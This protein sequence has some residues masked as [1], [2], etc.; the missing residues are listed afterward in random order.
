[1]RILFDL[2]HPAH[3]HFFR[4][5][6]ARL[7]GEGHEVRFTGRDKDILVELARAYGIPLEVFGVAPKAHAATGVRATTG[8]HAVENALHL[9][10]ELLQRQWHLQR[11]IRQWRPDAMMAIAG[12]YVSSLGYLLRV[13][14]YVFYDTEHAT[15]S[16]LLAYPF[17]TCIYV[18]RCYRKAIRWRHERYNGY[19]ELAYLHPRYF[20]PD[21]AVMGE[22]GLAPGERFAIVRLV[23]WG[24]AH[25]IGRAGFT[26]EN[27]LRLV[28]ELGR[29]ARV[30]VSCEGELPR[31]L[32]PQRLRLPVARI[33]HLMAH[34]ALVFGESATM[35]SE[36]AVLG[37]P[38]VYVDPVG[39]GYTDEEE[40][41]YG[42]VFNFT[43]ERQDEAIAR[44][45]EILREGRTEE[46]R[47]RGRRLVAEKIDVT[48]MLHRI[49]L[50]RPYAQRRK[51]KG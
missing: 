12:T 49:A 19:H 42:L 3:L 26:R 14:T 38:G 15:L 25:D 23:A 1:M 20:T 47:A 24:A 50:E 17:A 22:A 32:E 51:A 40:R 43:S 31:E 28:R 2:Q 5:V 33:H 45:V 46:W 27:K 13:P 6:A 10:L 39:R 18:P 29:H 44:G 34:A 8:L 35:A 37:V 7:A 9:G 48:E 36:G 11:I 16:N 30:L 41:D 4:N 21:P